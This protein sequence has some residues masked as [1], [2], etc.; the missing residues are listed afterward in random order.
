MMGRK[1]QRAVN[2]TEY[3]SQEPH[4]IHDEM[5]D[6]TPGLHPDNIHDLEGDVSIIPNTKELFEE[7]DKKENVEARS[8][9]K[10]FSPTEEV[11]QAWKHRNVALWSPL[12]D[13][14]QTPIP[15]NQYLLPV[16]QLVPYTQMHLQCGTGLQELILQNLQHKEIFCLLHLTVL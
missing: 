10:L 8:K 9:I 4:Y 11:L 14:M 3:F 1:S 5:I 6:A 12:Q 7:Q 15:S 13:I 2:G 16:A